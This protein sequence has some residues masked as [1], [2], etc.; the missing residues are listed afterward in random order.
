MKG[1]D[2]S[3]E[4]SVTLED[5]YKGADKYFDLDGESIK[6]KIKPGIADGQTL[7][8]TG[9]GN[10]GYNGG[11]KGDLLLKIHVLKDPMFERKENDLYTDL[12]VNLYIAILGGKAP[13]KTLKGTINI[14]IQKNLR[15]ESFE[16]LREWECRFMEKL[17]LSEIFMLRYT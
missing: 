11:P 1:Q 8:L 6:L 13:L 17:I 15:M 16:G 2:V 10:P 9:K 12:R 3:A 5:A 7:K 14:N 4:M